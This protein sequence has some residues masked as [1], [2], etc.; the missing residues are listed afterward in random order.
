[1]ERIISILTGAGYR[2][3]SKP[4][5]ISSLS[6]DFAGALVA[7]QRALD[8]IIVIDL[9]TERDEQRLV[10][11]VQ[12]LGRALD[13]MQSRRSLTTVIVGSELSTSALE[14]LS[15]VCRVLAVGSP[16][17]DG[18]ERYLHDWLAILLPLP[19]IGEV[20]SL[21][22]WRA[23][24][25]LKLGETKEDV[26]ARTLVEAANRSAK[27]VEVAFGTLVRKE[28]RPTLEEQAK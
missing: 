10:Q 18:I 5:S 13:L 15:K 2:Q 14:S 8:L 21:A 28:I 20:S 23:E 19:A 6:F 7:N 25:S 24:L 3:L 16:P 4:F 22:D 17:E 1:V 12:S 9:I 11:K 27:S 26:V